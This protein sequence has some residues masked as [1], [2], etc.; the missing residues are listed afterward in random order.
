VT[1]TYDVLVVGGGPAGS[2]TALSVARLGYAVGLLEAQ[3]MPRPHIGESI[4][5][6]VHVQLSH[7]GL[8]DVLDRCDRRDF[9]VS[10][11]QWAEGVPVVK[12][13][14]PG[15]GTVNRGMFDAA[16]LEHCSREGAEVMTRRRA[17]SVRRDPSCGWQVTL[18]EGRV[19]RARF[20][21]DATGRRGILPRLRETTGARTIALYAYWHSDRLPTAP[22][23]SGSEAAWSW[24]APVGGLGFNVTLFVDREAIVGGRDSVRRA[25]LEGVDQVRMFDTCADFRSCSNVA[26]CDATAWVD[27]SAVG[28]D[29]IKVGEAAQSLDPLASMGIQKAIQTAIWASV[30]INT[31]L[32]RS[33]TE[34]G[35]REF[36]QKKLSASAAAHAATVAEIYASATKWALAP[37]WMRRSVLAARRVKVGTTLDPEAVPS[38][39]SPIFVGN[40]PIIDH[41]CICGDFIEMRR[42][43]LVGPGDEPVAFV[44][45][46]SLGKVI[47]RVGEGCA[48]GDFQT[49][50]LAHIDGGIAKQLTSWLFRNDVVRTA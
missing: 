32:R 41:P 23:I 21:V 12:P 22:K 7:L 16:L 39:S 4:S 27:K 6:G 17:S 33:A 47:D 50:M 8:G 15:A 26:A 42:A 37:F 18:D 25:Y 38:P 5:V 20:L 11:S 46:L 30:V 13:A 2:I 34:A 1:G 14:A 43:V 49:W 48:F 9:H 40:A 31:M 28:R 10:Q 36:Y 29:F 19:L 3:P 24:G 45:G 44:N 35:A